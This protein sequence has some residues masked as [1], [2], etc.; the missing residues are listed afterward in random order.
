MKKLAI[1]ISLLAGATCGYSQG[2]INWTDYDAATSGP[3]PLGS[4]YIE[5]WGPNSSNTRITGNTANDLPAGSQTYPGSTLLSGSGY[6]VGLYLST[7]SAGVQS[8]VTSG[9]PVATDTFMTG[10][11][12]AGAWTYNALTVADSSIGAG[13][14]VF[15]EL[16]AWSTAQGATSYAAALTEGVAAGYS[17]PST[18]TTTLGGGSPPTTAGTLAGIGLTDFNLTTS[19]PEPS[20]IALGVI[21]AS[22]FLMRLRRKQ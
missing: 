18:G 20:T 11:G 14:A 19:T 16:A 5:I 8:A 2:S 22:A 15:V 1:T 10:S 4:F 9:T 6:E 17:N 21:G 12:N 3:P 7:T 13:T